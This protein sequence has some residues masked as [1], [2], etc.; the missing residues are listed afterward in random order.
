MQT[1][2]NLKMKHNFFSLIVISFAQL[3]FSQE[4]TAKLKPIEVDGFY[5]LMISPEIRSVS[6]NNGDVLR[7]FDSKKNEIP[8]VFLQKDNNTKSHKSFEIISKNAIANK[9]TEVV[10]LNKNAEKLNQIWLKIANTDVAKRF[11]ISGSNDGNEWFG[12]VDNQF[13]DGLSDQKSTFVVRA[14]YF[15]SNQYKYLKFTFLDKNSLPVNVMEAFSKS[16]FQNSVFPIVLNDFT[17][18]IIQNK[19]NK[20]TVITLQFK[21]PQVVDAVKIEV[22]NPNFYL[23]NAKISVPK[24]RNYKKR[25]EIFEELV[26]L[27]QLSSKNNK[28][29]VISSVLSKEFTITIENKDNSPLEISKI[30]WYQNPVSL[31]ADFKKGENYTMIINPKLNKPNYDLAESGINFNQNFPKAQLENLDQL[32]ENKTENEEKNFWQKPLFMWICIIFTMGI[33][34]FFA[35]GLVKDMNKE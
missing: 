33:I 28:T 17:Q 9:L 26:S 3:F 15:P 4:R 24:R 10:V 31:L 12:L 19:E 18:K 14:F 35:L 1:T 25:T 11:N 23:R 34:A 22:S 16:Q 13:V 20:E 27:F 32:S 30:N 8:Y 2:Q 29:Q 6:K 5:Q 21:E 7:I